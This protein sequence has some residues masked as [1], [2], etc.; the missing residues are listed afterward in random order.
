VSYLFTQVSGVKK[1]VKKW[2]LIVL[3]ITE[4]QCIVAKQE[5][6]QL[7]IQYAN[8]LQITSGYFASFDKLNNFLRSFLSLCRLRGMVGQISEIFDLYSWRSDLGGVS[9]P[10]FLSFAGL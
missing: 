1:G 5:P 9:L 6:K 4:I 7:P 10:N 3:Q 2:E 8:N